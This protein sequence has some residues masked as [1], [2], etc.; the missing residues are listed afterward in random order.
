MFII[1]MFFVGYF[2]LELAMVISGLAV[3]ITSIVGLFNISL[4]VSIPL[5]VI[6]LVLA[7][8]ISRYRRGGFL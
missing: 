3:L 5:F 2:A 1:A 4:S 8:I 7:Y 6:S